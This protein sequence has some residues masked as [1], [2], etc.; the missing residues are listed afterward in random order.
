M[1]IARIYTSLI[2]LF[3]TSGIIAQSEDTIESYDLEP[4]EERVLA[5]LDDIYLLTKSSDKGLEFRWAPT[6]VKTWQMGIDH[7]YRLEKIAF[8]ADTTLVSLTDF[9]L[10]PSKTI[11]PWPLDNWET[12]V[13]EERPY[14][15]IAAMSIYGQDKSSEKGFVNQAQALENRHGFNVL[16]ADLDNEAAEASGLY[17]VEKEKSILKSD[18]LYRVFT[19]DETTGESSDTAYVMAIYNEDQKL[20]APT[21]VDSVEYENAIAIRWYNQRGKKKYSAYHIERSSDGNTFTRLTKKPFINAVTS[22]RPENDMIT[23]I[24]SVEQNGVDYYYRVIGIDA[25]ASESPASKVIIAQ[26]KEKVNLTSPINVEVKQKDEDKL[27]ITWDAPMGIAENNIAGYKVMK[28]LHFEDEFIPVTKN[29][30]SNDTYS[31]TDTNPDSRETNYYYV[32]AIDQKGNE[33]QSAMAFGFTKDDIAPQPPVNLIADIDTL[34]NVLLEWEAPQD[35]D[36]RGY[37][38]FWSYEKEGNYAVQSGKLLPN[39]HFVDELQLKS[40]TEIVYYYVIAVDYSYNRSEASEIYTLK[41]PDI[42]PP[43]ASIFAD[44]KV[45]EDGIYFEWIASSSLDVTNIKLERSSSEQESWT[46]IESFDMKKNSFLDAN[47]EGGKLYQYRLL[48]IDDDGNKSYN[49]KPLALEALTPFFIPSITKLTAEKIDGNLTLNWEYDNA[50]EYEYMVYRQL[51]NGTLKSLKK[52]IGKTTFLDNGN[53]DKAQYAVVAKAKDG[54]ESK[55]SKM[56]TAK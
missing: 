32:V 47:V 44:Y 26:G 22:L 21:L 33:V 52:V 11:K 30:L 45:S 3:I 5:P 49:I 19:F 12:I 50:Q 8:K 51:V 15:A 18:G 27:V 20:D 53:I 28:A 38:V 6:N 56:V 10:S 14:C 48:T 36:I 16:A 42:I 13:N 24:D 1:K 2:C 43:A 55:I 4:L 54:R 37:R 34:G 23:Y 39:T 7:G 46:T 29:T 17:F 41:K 40:L 9:S 35:N 25:F 31:F